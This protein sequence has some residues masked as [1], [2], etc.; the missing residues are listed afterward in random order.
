MRHRIEFYGGPRGSDDGRDD[1]QIWLRLRP[2]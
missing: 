1:Q 2:S